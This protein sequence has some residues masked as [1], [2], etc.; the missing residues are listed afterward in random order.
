[1]AEKKTEGSFL[2]LLQV[3]SCGGLNIPSMSCLRLIIMVIW[4]PILF[5]PTDPTAELPRF[6][7][8][9]DLPPHLQIALERGSFLAPLVSLS[10]QPCLAAKYHWIPKGSTLTPESPEYSGSS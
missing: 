9:L 7:V 5:F 2:L 4:S 8:S 3:Y 1:M 6:L 10:P